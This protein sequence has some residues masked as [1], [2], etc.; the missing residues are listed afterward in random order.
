MAETRG[1]QECTARE[2]NVRRGILN[3]DS[4]HFRIVNR[5]VFEYLAWTV[6]NSLTDTRGRRTICTPPDVIL[7]TSLLNRERDDRRFLIHFISY[8]LYQSVF[9]LTIISLIINL[10][11][12]KLMN[13]LYS[14]LTIFKFKLYLCFTRVENINAINKSTLCPN[15]N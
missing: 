11:I 12:S 14:F 10:K 9:L 8:Q 1:T 15:C 2:Y 6:F 3:L 4:R 7:I 5:T 13:T